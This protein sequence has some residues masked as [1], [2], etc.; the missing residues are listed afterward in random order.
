MLTA[1]LALLAVLNKDIPASLA[2]FALTFSN[3]VC[4]LAK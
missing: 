1:F 3:K 4:F 2:G